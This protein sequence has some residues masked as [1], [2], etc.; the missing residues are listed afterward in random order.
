MQDLRI[1]HGSW[2]AAAL[3][4]LLGLPACSTQNVTLKAMVGSDLNPNY[5]GGTGILD[6]YV[7]FLKK[8][9]VFAANDKLLADFL[10]DD[11]RAQKKPP[12]WLADDTIAIELMQ[13]APAEADAWPVVEKRVEVP[14]GATHVGLI[15]AFQSHA[16]ND[17][18]EQWR[19]VVP[20]SGGTAA[21]RVAGKKL[22]PMS[23][24]PARPSTQPTQEQAQQPKKKETPR[25]GSTD[26]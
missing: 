17:N 2:W 16:D 20:V 11:V 10:V 14:V 7:F 6:V 23:P 3:V 9:D 4:T 15:A 25:A 8:T 1:R 12:S 5:T 26:R 24:P 18:D 19:L 21:F 13:I 22:E